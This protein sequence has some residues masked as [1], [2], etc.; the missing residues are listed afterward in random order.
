MTLEKD[1]TP[2]EMKLKIMKFLGS[3]RNM[4]E[5]P[6]ADNNSRDIP[7]VEPVNI[8]GESIEEFF[9]KGHNRNEMPL[10]PEES[11]DGARR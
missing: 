11:L 6:L 9:V 7:K 2:E 5:A 1:L 8:E 10:A 4:D 3:G